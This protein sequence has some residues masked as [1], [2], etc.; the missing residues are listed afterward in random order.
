[1]PPNPFLFCKSNAMMQKIL[2]LLCL[3]SG[4][5]LLTAQTETYA[6]H[7]SSADSLFNIEAYG[8]AA[9]RYSL[10]FEVLG[11][12]GYPED[13]LKAARAWSRAGNPD[14]AFFH[15][16]RR[17]E[18]TK[19]LD[20]PLV[21]ESEP[22]FA[23]LKNEFRWS[24]LMTRIALKNERLAAL[25]NDPLSLELEQ[26]RILDQWYRVRWDSVI[27]LH[28]RKSPEFQDFLRRNGEQDSLNELR[29]T[30]ILDERGWL[31]PEEVGEKGSSALY[32]VIQHADLPVQEKYLP[33]MQKAVAAGKASPSN[34]AYLEDRVLMRQ[35]KPQRYGSQI[36][37]DKATGAWVLYEVEDPPNL[38]KRRASVGLG[39]I[40][41]YLDSTGASMH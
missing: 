22:D 5:L 12:R 14:S 13:R 21:L 7:V 26:I 1:M 10:A 37:P 18:K 31:G 3:L 9:R 20:D 35:G 40:Q 38:D 19:L 25:K 28:S 29:V 36:V 4:H 16:N 33:M 32:L 15:L 2:S 11:G 30:Q 34:L 6:S 17:V 39:P 27:A 8:Q 24:R 23:P 41:E